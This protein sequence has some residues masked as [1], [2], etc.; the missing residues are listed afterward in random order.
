VDKQI[1]MSQSAFLRL[2]SFF[3]PDPDGPEPS[4]P[5]GPIVRTR[6]MALATRMAIAQIGSQ[7]TFAEAVLG[8][9]AG[10]RALEIARTSVSEFLDDCGTPPHRH[11]WPWPWPLVEPIGP[12]EQLVAG[13][14]FELAAR[15]KSPLQETFAAA[16]D[17][18]TKL[19]LQGLQKQAE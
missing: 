2:L 18:L 3:N 12:L 4:G 15:V 6:R 17:Q 1:T 13:A 16:G 7:F 10:G 19:G 14:Q 11:P 9:D 8:R 5:I